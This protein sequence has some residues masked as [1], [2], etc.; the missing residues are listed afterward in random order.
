MPTS[1][2]ETEPG[3]QSLVCDVIH[4]F[5]SKDSQALSIIWLRILRLLMY[6]PQEMVGIQRT[7]RLLFG[8]CLSWHYRKAKHLNIPT[9]VCISAYV[10]VLGTS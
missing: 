7:M 4:S 9:H 3:N 6:Q 2:A 1:G 5:A 8:F 10:F